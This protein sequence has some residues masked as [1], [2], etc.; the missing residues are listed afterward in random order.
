MASHARLRTACTSARRTRRVCRRS[1][2][3]ARDAVDRGLV[4]VEAGSS[5]RLHRYDAEGHIFQL[6]TSKPWLVT[7]QRNASEEKPTTQRHPALAADDPQPGTPVFDKLDSLRK[8]NI[9]NKIEAWKVEQAKAKQAA[10]KK[11][12]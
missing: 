7:A 10:A 9:A 8:L 12:S 11:G 6:E 5:G 2:D 1:K 3:A 4:E